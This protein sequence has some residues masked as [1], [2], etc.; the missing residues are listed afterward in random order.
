MFFK[1]SHDGRII[2]QDIEILFT[3]PF[4]YMFPDAARSSKCLIREDAKTI[5]NLLLLGDAMAEP[6][7]ENGGFDSNI[8]AIFTYLGQFIDHDI[9]ARTD[10]EDD[11][12]KNVILSKDG[13]PAKISPKSP[14]VI[15]QKLK[16][17]RR[18]FFDLDSVYGDGAS[19]IKST[20]NTE[21]SVSVADSLFE[22]D[23]YRF[24]VTPLMDAP[25]G[26]L[27][28]DLYREGRE[29]LI[30]DE[31]NDENL[32][33]S[34]LHC[35]FL[36][37]HNKLYDLFKVAGLSS[38]EAYLEARQR[39]RWAYQY[40][41]VNDYLKQLCHPA[42]VSECLK[43][44]PRY[45][46]AGTGETEMFMPLE[47]SVAGFRIG[48][49]MVRP[50]YKLN[51]ESG[52][53]PSKQECPFVFNGK[54]DVMNIL[55]T[56]QK[57][58]ITKPRSKNVDLLKKGESE[59]FAINPITA[60]VWS[61]FTHIDDNIEPQKARKIDPLL[62][63]GLQDMP[64]ITDFEKGTVARHLA[65]RNLLRSFLLSIP[66]GQALC[67]A[68]GVKA[69]SPSQI[70]QSLSDSEN[71]LDALA[72][73]DFLTRTPLWAY[74]LI[75]GRIHANGEH[76]GMLGSTLMTE[77]LVGMLKA[78]PNSYWNQRVSANDDIIGFNGIT[79]Y[80]DEEASYTISTIG[81]L[82]KFAMP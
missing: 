79:L 52:E 39:L 33:L 63:E 5:E 20:S 7:G 73:G 58:D 60:I 9:T 31:R 64:T 19:L 6:S 56:N 4:G 75:E 21:G 41:V 51:S 36:L 61:G 11:T 18:P 1:L 17:G 46:G 69:I 16:N 59:H 42:I 34:Q 10:R 62:S 43:Y 40:I 78:D 29:A 67:Q 80:Q 26:S 55:A 66:T 54:L 68:I 12:V 77:T 13:S 32:N 74:L 28:H 72:R 25:E 47:F 37:A 44:G 38:V 23:E 76:L 57:P 27:K 45:F 22:D 2:D 82:I 24:K 3:T 35:A 30:A 50:E 81:D 14:D 53:L 70:A 65:K 8:P 15:T 48:H 71:L 49:S